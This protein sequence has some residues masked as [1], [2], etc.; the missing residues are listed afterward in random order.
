MRGW[1]VLDIWFGPL[2]WT[3]T[4]LKRSF[5]SVPSFSTTLTRWRWIL[6]TT[7]PHPFQ[8]HFPKILPRHPPRAEAPPA[9]P[10]TSPQPQPALNPPHPTS[11]S[12]T[13]LYSKAWIVIKN[14][15]QLSICRHLSDTLETQ[16]LWHQQAGLSLQ[17]S[18]AKTKT[19]L[20]LMFL[21][22]CFSGTV[23]D[24]LDG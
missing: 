8:T 23:T 20:C 5:S 11:K 1:V 14:V 10:T 24:W 21:C 9:L 18:M 13:L 15:S 3:L 22:H 16:H 6:W 7:L 4:W 17:F 12:T 2:H 19:A